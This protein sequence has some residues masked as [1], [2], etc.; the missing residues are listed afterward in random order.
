MAAFY[1]YIRMKNI[2]LSILVMASLVIPIPVALA[3]D[4]PTPG[5][6]TVTLSS[7]ES[8]SVAAQ[9]NTFEIKYTGLEPVP[10]CVTTPCDFPATA[11]F[12]LKTK[13]NS[14]ADITIIEGE[15]YTGF[16][17][18]IKFEKVETNDRVVI[19]A[20]LYRP[21]NAH[22]L[23]TN[24][25]TSDGTVY[26]MTTEQ[27]RR[28]YSSPGAFLSYGFNSF[29]N[30][31]SA[32]SADMDIAL[33]PIT[34]PQ[35][36][37]IVCSDRGADQGTCYVMTNGHKAGFVSAEVFYGQGYTFARALYGDVSFMTTDS[38]IGSATE[39]HRSGALINNN[40]TVQMVSITSGGLLG[41]PSLN[42]FNSWGFS[43]ADVVPSNAADRQL[44]Q[45][46]VLRDRQPG[47]L[48][49]HLTGKVSEVEQL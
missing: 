12:T 47:E 23:G 1:V 9:N 19:T 3:A 27:L 34:A 24:I 22:P 7:G 28:P 36:G 26:T 17:L 20:Q 43:F 6:Q 15:T 11:K 35:D 39:Q 10:L 40:G 4:A 46:T 18:M 30:L 37:R 45:T 25:V 8:V 29:A 49:I 33:G 44:S 5:P 38:N 21:A 32:N 48:H 31:V 13:G 16:S 42:V 14:H 2:I 41:F